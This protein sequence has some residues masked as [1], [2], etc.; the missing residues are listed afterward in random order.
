MSYAVGANVL[1]TEQGHL[2][3]TEMVK[4]H[5]SLRNRVR[6]LLAGVAP[7]NIPVG[8]TDTRALAVFLHP[9]AIK[10]STRDAAD[11]IVEFAAVPVP[12]GTILMALRNVL[13]EG[14]DIYDIKFWGMIAGACV[15]CG[16]ERGAEF[17]LVELH[18]VALTVKLLEQLQGGPSPIVQSGLN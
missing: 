9:T 2:L 7:A 11:A 1:I 5:C 15:E 4:R 16:V 13:A 8:E 3:F 10:W 6:E 18:L 14:Q 12:G 17:T